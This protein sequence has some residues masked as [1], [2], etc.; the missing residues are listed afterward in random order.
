MMSCRVNNWTFW[1]N[2]KCPTLA[3]LLAQKERRP[4]EENIFKQADFPG[5]PK[6]Y[7]GVGVLYEMQFI[8]K[9]FQLVF[10]NLSLCFR[11]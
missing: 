11:K 2:T 5:L 7:F 4:V 1:A 10:E 3:R 6:C 9:C 8:S